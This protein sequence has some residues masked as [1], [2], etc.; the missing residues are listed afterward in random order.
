MKTKLIST[1]LIAVFSILLWTFISFSNEYS[2]SLKVPVAVE[3]IPEGFALKELSAK[4]ITINVKGQGWQLAN[5][6]FGF[7]YEFSFR[8]DKSELKK[9]VTV[10]TGLEQS[11][12]FPGS[13]QLIVIEPERI[14]YELERISYKK[15]KIIDSVKI[16]TKPGFGLVSPIR[17]MPDSVEISGPRSVISTI[18]FV[19]TDEIVVEDVDKKVS[20]DVSLKSLDYVRYQINTAKIE[21]D[22]QRIVDKVFEGIPV[23]TVNVPYLRDLTLFPNK[24][25][26]ILRGGINMLGKLDNESINAVIDFKQ[27]L[28]DSLGRIEP[29]IEIPSFTILID[30]KPRNL[31]Y[32]IKQY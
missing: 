3:D 17:L 9:T 14:S 1:I 27:A 23:R 32:I 6:V 16:N 13:I 11:S 2:T 4:Q 18:N 5:L 19:K 22:V 29:N 30:I 8:A 28:E 25:D 15:V 7:D 20:L 21:A 10:R 31:E 26:V 24:V 12:W